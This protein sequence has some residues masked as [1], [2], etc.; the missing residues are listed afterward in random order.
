MFPTRDSQRFVTVLAALCA[1]FSIQSFAQSIQTPGSRAVSRALI[2]ENVYPYT[3][4]NYA[5]PVT[6]LEP[7]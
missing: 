7:A 3:V 4:S 6:I 5:P 1:L 2:V